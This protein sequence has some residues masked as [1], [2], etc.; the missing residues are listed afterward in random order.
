MNEA[1]QAGLDAVNK[2]RQMAVAAQAECLINRISANRKGI[3]GYQDQIAVEQKKNA[4]L[5]NDLVT[6]KSVL[7]YEF[8]GTLNPNQVTILNAIKKIN[9]SRQEQ[10]S[11]QFQ[12]NSNVIDNHLKT[13]AA[14]TGEIN[15]WV[16]QL[17]ALSVDVV[18]AAQV[19]G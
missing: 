8:T 9:E 16:K 12:K 10:V 18:T 1:T 4:D 13:I 19:T 17:N 3:Q 5:S 7:G 2:S 11:L 14:L 15:E 6:Q